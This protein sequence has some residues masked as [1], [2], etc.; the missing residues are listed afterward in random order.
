M[1]EQRKYRTWTAQQKVEIVLAGLRGDRTVKEVC[2]QH[3][4]A[5]TLYYRWKSSMKKRVCVK[6]TGLVGLGA[7]PLAAARAVAER[8]QS[9]IR[10]RGAGQSAFRGSGAQSSSAAVPC[11]RGQTFM[12]ARPSGAKRWSGA[13]GAFKWSTGVR[14]RRLDG[15]RARRPWSL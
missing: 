12:R 8:L 7:W 14:L 4:I 5:E 3:E 9:S 2:R 13:R 15:T 11:W 1:S 10:P 6:V